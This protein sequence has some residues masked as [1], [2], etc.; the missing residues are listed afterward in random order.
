METW[1]DYIEKKKKPVSDININGHDF[2]LVKK[3]G[4]Q[5][6]KV[7]RTGSVIEPGSI[8]KEPIIKYYKCLKCGTKIR[9]DQYTGLK[10]EDPEHKDIECDYISIVGIL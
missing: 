10:F 5:I 7:H 2:V 9:I 3:T 4:G 8:Q 6:T 1:K